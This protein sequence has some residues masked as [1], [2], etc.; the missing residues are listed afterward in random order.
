MLEAMACG[1][2]VVAANVG[3]IPGVLLDG[4]TGLLFP[5]EDVAALAGAAVK[6]LADPKKR[7]EMGR[8]GRRRVERDFS[9]AEMLERTA[10]LYS[11]RRETSRLTPKPGEP[12]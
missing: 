5:S 4:V 11:A 2:A 9:Q 3:G 7:S 6:L 8:A 1:K 12:S 10:A